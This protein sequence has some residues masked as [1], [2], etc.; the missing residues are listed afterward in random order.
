MQSLDIIAGVSR[1][2]QA[3]VLNDPRSADMSYPAFTFLR[4]AQVFTSGMT[5]SRARPAFRTFRCT[6][7]A[8]KAYSEDYGDH[9]RSN[10]PLVG[11]V[12]T[13]FCE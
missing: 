2:I 4:G 13:R 6:R 8:L 1:G 7:P 5:T 11:G 3:L 10:E 12:I 9:A